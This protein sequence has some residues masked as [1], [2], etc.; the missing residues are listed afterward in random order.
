MKDITNNVILSNIE[1]A[2]TIKEYHSI[3]LKDSSL[4]DIEKLFLKIIKGFHVFPLEW[5]MGT[6]F[7]ARKHDCQKL[8]TNTKDLIYRINPSDCGR[9]NNIGQ[10][11]FYGTMNRDT[12]FVEMRLKKGDE[13][14]LLESERINV[15]K[16]IL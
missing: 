9:F 15:A 5:K 12:A 11:L 13:V 7:R 3:N 10:S 6:L 4:S 14:T 2:E 8:F 16:K 1:L